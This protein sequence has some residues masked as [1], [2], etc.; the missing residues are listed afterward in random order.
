MKKTAEIRVVWVILGKNW[1]DGFAYPE[2]LF[3]SC[4]YVQTWVTLLSLLKK[5]LRYCDNPG[6]III[7]KGLFTQKCSVIIFSISLWAFMTLCGTQKHVSVVIQLN[8]VGCFGPYWPLYGG[9]G[10]KQL[11]HSPKYFFCVFQYW[12]WENDDKMFIFA[13]NIPLI[14]VNLDT[15]QS[16]FKKTKQKQKT[17]VTVIIIFQ[18]IAIYE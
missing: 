18:I 13:I 4:W 5:M 1:L 14:P 15:D 2:K 8:S 6:E 10:G 17:N 9:W 3:D 11:K 7:L 12:K 16:R